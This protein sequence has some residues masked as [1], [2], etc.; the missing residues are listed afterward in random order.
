MARDLQE[1]GLSATQAQDEFL[2]LGCERFFEAGQVS[3]H[4]RG[5]FHSR[6]GAQDNVG[7][8]VEEGRPLDLV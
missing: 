4:E 6:E 3:V 8:N 7:E 1:E 2:L 5:G